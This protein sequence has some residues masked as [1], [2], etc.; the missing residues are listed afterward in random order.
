MLDYLLFMA[1]GI[2]DPQ[3]RSHV[4]DTVGDVLDRV[5]SLGGFHIIDSWLAKL[6][7]AQLDLQAIML[8]TSMLYPA[9]HKLN[10]W[11][12]FLGMV[13]D[14]LQKVEPTRVDALLYGFDRPTP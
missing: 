13:R 14:H 6:D 5:L 1:V 7:L 9:Q 11:S 12:P 4:E 10:E 3:L 2:K 8:V